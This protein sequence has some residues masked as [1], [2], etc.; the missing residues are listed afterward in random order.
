MPSLNRKVL[1]AVSL[2]LSAAAGF[3]FMLVFK[4]T[5]VTT[6]HKLPAH[7]LQAIVGKNIFLLSQKAIST[8]FTSY[9]PFIKQISL[10]KHYPN[11][12]QL[13]ITQEKVYIQINNSTNFIQVTQQGKI[14]K[15]TSSS[16]KKLLLISSFQ[17]LRNHEVELG[18]LIQQ[19]EILY[20]IKLLKP[21]NNSQLTVER[22]IIP[23]PTL[24][25][26]ITT[27]GTE[28]TVSIKKSI[29]KNVLIV[30]NS[31]IGLSKKG[32]KAKTITFEFDKPV[33]TL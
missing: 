16:D 21:I 27:Q 28:I 7:L 2:L 32:V 24:V 11:K 4:V 5:S 6:N 18:Q 20:A 25:K 22:I 26:L 14:L 31:I 10:T 13:Q 30:H 15:L 19:P 3:T 12:I 29:A 8:E 33:I 23:R 17:K 1:L 9:D